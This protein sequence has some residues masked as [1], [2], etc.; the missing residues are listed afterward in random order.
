[1]PV[2]RAH[3]LLF[4]E[5]YQV[6]YWLSENIHCREAEGKT[7]WLCGCPWSSPLQLCFWSFWFQVAKVCA[8]CKWIIASNL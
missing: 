8:V 5:T 2:L 4:H 7:E 1:M 3:V 6:N